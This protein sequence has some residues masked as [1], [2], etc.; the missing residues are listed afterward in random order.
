MV[1]ATAALSSA[2]GLPSATSLIPYLHNART[3]ASVT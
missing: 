3:Y 1:L 2:S